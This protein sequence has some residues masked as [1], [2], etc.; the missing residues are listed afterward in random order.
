MSD[1]FDELKGLIIR[2]GMSAWNV[3]NKAGCTERTIHNWLTGRVKEPR[4]STALAVAKLFGKAIM[5]TDGK[6]QIVDAMPDT[7]ATV[8]MKMQRAHEFVGYWRRWQ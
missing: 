1:V 3:A 6:A 2:S 5:L 8:A 7:P 4:L